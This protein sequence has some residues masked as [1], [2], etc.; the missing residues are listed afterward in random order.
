[1]K[2]LEAVLSQLQ[3]H[4]FRV[5]QNKCVF[6]GESVEYL[7]HKLDAQGL[8][9]LPHKVIAIKE[10][11]VP[12]NVAELRLFL[13]LLNYYAKFIPNLSFIIFPL[14]RLL[15]KGEPWK[16]SSECQQAFQ[17]A[18]DLLSSQKVLAHFDPSLPLYLAAD[19]SAYGI[20][21]VIS[22]KYPDGSERPIYSICL[23]NTAL[24]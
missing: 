7:G 4:G 2:T 17:R 13:G 15:N 10:A 1:M 21:A 16:W 14:N 11:P 3:T 20:G 22:H 6:L 8:H 5:H 9:A 19:A 23:A 12:T 18:K 24:K